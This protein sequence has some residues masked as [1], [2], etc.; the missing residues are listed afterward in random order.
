MRPNTQQPSGCEDRVSLYEEVTDR[1]VRELET[2]TVPWVQPWETSSA[3]LGLPRS[4]STRRNYSGINI[5]ILWDAVIGQGFTSPEWLTFRQALSLGGHVRK[6][7][8]GTVI[9]YADTFFPKDERERARQ[10]GDDPVTVA[11]P[12]GRAQIW[13]A[14]RLRTRCAPLRCANACQS[15]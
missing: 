11:F 12:F 1:I 15:S 2:G 7:E 4:A 5:L 3:A 14:G 13:P 10:E 8:R 9:C 6:G